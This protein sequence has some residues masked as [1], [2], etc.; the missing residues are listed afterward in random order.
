[1]QYNFA[2]GV[3]QPDP[4]DRLNS[5]DRSFDG[6][7]YRT[8][9]QYDNAGLLT[10]IQYPEA[11]DCLQYSYD[12]L[13][14]L[15]EVKGFT[16]GIT[17][18]VNGALTGLTY[19]NGVTSSYGYDTNNRLRDYQVTLSGTSILQQQFTYDNNNNITAIT[20]GSNTKTFDY[21]ANNQL[22]RS[23]T[24]G[25]FLES[26]QT[27]GAYGVKIGDY[28]G[29]KVM[30]FSP[31]LTAMMGL[32]Y[33]SSSIGI[34]FGTTAPGVKKI[35]VIPDG[36]FTVHRVTQKSLDLYTSADNSTYTIIPRSNW[37]FATDSKGVIT[38]TL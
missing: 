23:I 18:N 5:V 14:Q 34:D 1:M 12:N 17:Y 26:D 31:V 38:I 30:D 20:E 27:S 29:A 32:D 28:L 3:Y 9:Y 2:D 33:N 22:V 13:N 37:T 19:A 24:T 11:T 15:S 6:V 8:A 10:K 16:N 36:K 21:D 25:Q 7:T 4:M 35:Q